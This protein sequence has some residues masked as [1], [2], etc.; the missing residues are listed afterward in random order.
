MKLLTF[1]GRSENIFMCTCATDPA[2]GMNPVL[3]MVNEIMNAEL[4]LPQVKNV[5][6]GHIGARR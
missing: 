2:R 4:L 3:D 5:A 6:S 1:S